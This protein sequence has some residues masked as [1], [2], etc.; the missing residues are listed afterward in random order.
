[1]KS[2]VKNIL[3]LKTANENAL[4]MER[5]WHSNKYCRF[6]MIFYFIKY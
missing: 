1:M 2:C 4:I 6:C 3:P 5:R